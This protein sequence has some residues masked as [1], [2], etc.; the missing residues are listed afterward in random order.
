MNALFFTLLAACA[1]ASCSPSKKN[2]P[3]ENSEELVAIQPATPQVPTSL[4]TVDLLKDYPKKDICLQDIADVS[5]IVL[6][7]T[8]Q[9]LLHPSEMMMYY[10]SDSLIVARTLEDRIVLLDGKG[11]VKN[12]FLHKGGGGEEYQAVNK[13]VADVERQEIYISDYGLLNRIQV[14]DFEGKYKRTLPLPRQTSVSCFQNFSSECLLVGDDNIS[15]ETGISKRKRP[16][17]L[18]SKKTGKV[19]EELP[20][21]F[22]KRVA[23]RAILPSADRLSAQVMQLAYNPVIR[24]YDGWIIGDVSMDTICTYSPQGKLSPLLCRTPSVYNKETP[25]IAFPSLMTSGFLILEYFQ[26][27]FDFSKPVQG[28]K[29]NEL[30][31]NYSK[32]EVYG[33]NQLTN[34]DF[35]GQSIGFNSAGHIDSPWWNAMFNLI[36]TERL[37]DAREEGKLSGPLK[38]IAAQ[39][40]EEDNPVLMVTRFKDSPSR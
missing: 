27:K 25:I 20:I 2:V 39:M 8:D 31:Y 18:L 15:Y 11:K 13:L 21:S 30:V 7:T 38:D 34:R 22:H 4:V 28:F 3:Q 6:E 23:S 35:S 5:Y 40:T 16:Y 19:V 37:L 29:T 33:L 32:G 36:P 24:Y 1:L 9:S 17:F 26:L 14:Y 12:T 10:V